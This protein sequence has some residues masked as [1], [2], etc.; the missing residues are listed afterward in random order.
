VFSISHGRT[1]YNHE[2]L[3]SFCGPRQYFPLSIKACVVFGLNYLPVIKISVLLSP[4]STAAELTTNR[5]TTATT[6][7]ATNTAR[8]RSHLLAILQR[9]HPARKDF[10]RRSQLISQA[11]LNISDFKHQAHN[12]PAFARPTSQSDFSLTPFPNPSPTTSMISRSPP[13][14][15]VSLPYSCCFGRSFPYLYRPAS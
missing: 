11:Q 7:P 12:F 9:F 6:A 2:P 4:R 14:P 15:F 13:R 5:K 1:D 8:T 10:N 3:I